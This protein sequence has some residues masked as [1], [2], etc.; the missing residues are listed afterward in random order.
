[1]KRRGEK[2][3]EQGKKKNGMKMGRGR[4]MKRGSGRGIR[5]REGERGKNER[6]VKRR[7]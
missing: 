3:S 2:K 1:M 6:K 5:K 7:R 4:E